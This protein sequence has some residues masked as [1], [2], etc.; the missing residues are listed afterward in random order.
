MSSETYSLEKK[1]VQ[2][3]AITSGRYDFSACQLDILFMLL[4]QLGKSDA[5][6]IKYTIYVK[7][8]M[9][10]T[11]RQWNYQQLQ[12]ATESMGG[13]MFV[14][15]TEKSLKQIWIFQSI[16][17]I[18]TKGYFEVS[19]SKDIKPYLFDLKNN[20]TVLE[21]KSA[22]S[23]SSKYAKRLYALGCQWRV[24]GEVILDLDKFK[25]M[26]YLKDP[27]GKEPE[28]FE[29]ISQLKERVLEIAKEQINKNTDISFDYEFLKKGRTVDSIKII[30]GSAKLK[31]IP[32]LQIDFNES[33]EYQKYVNEIKS[34]GLHDDAAKELAKSEKSMLEFKKVVFE[35][36]EEIVKTKKV[37]NDPA[38]YL[39]GVLQNKG[40]LKKADA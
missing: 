25:E 3:N 29:R 23:C 39:V 31:N 33:V 4:A 26:L 8:I 37:I 17:Y 21:L 5:N 18:K 32:Q 34:Y 38:A 15:E 30:I 1:I 35:L 14:V 16:E 9:A 10:I 22:L 19:L 6:D 11:G 24:R 13:R 12:E 28:K 27:K 20:F 2:H 7:D 36:N 40:L